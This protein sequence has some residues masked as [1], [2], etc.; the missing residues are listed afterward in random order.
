MLVV[1]ST[2]NIAACSLNI[3]LQLNLMFNVN[4]KKLNNLKID[5][6]KSHLIT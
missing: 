1:I 2:H 6:I 4:E 3:L 5:I